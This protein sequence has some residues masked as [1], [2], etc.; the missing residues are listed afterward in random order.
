MEILLVGYG[1]IGARHRA[2]LEAR[3][4]C[5]TV[6]SRN[7]SCPYE[8]FDDLKS[9]LSHKQYDGLLVAT[10]TA[11]HLENLKELTEAGFVGRVLI[12]KPLFAIPVDF[13]PY[14]P[15]QVCVAYNLRCHPLLKRVKELLRGR[16]LYSFWAYVGQHLPQ[17]R[18]GRDYRSIYSASKEEGGGALLDLSHEL[19]YL[20]WLAGPW[21]RVTAR[22]GRVSDLE[23]SSDDLY[24]L[25]IETRDCRLVQVQVNYLDLTPGGRREFIIN[26]EGLSLKGDFKTGLLSLNGSEPEVFSLD[27]NHTYAEQLRCWLEDEHESLCSFQE[28]LET[29]RLA[30]AA[31]QADA[32]DRWV[33]R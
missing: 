31:E 6:V 10:P 2:L 16:T 5:I 32:G 26:A 18:P 12:E 11:R 25:M 7:Q 24:G 21:Q 13:W 17:W 4:C 29:V 19:D 9:A 3:G 8:R 15:A 22:G 14:P 1:S 20:Q 23:I 30:A 28:G 27:R 33:R